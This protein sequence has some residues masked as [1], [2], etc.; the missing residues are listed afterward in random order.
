MVGFGALLVSVGCQAG[1]LHILWAA[2]APQLPHSP[3][4]P[5]H[6]QTSS[7]SR[8]GPALHNKGEE[9][10]VSGHDGAQEMEEK[11]KVLRKSPKEGGENGDLSLSAGKP[12]PGRLAPPR[13]AGC[14]TLQV[15]ALRSKMFQLVEATSCLLH[16]EHLLFPLLQKHPKDS[17]EFN[18][19]CSHRALQR[20]EQFV[21]DLHEAHQ[22]LQSVI[23]KLIC[24]LA[25]FPSDSS[26]PV[27]SALREILQNPLAV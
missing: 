20:E 6:T 9:L 7:A 5:S 10:V 12:R 1:D 14:G 26:I 17:N 23:E 13:L 27:Q 8:F 16:V 19:I 15:M 3:S 24:S 22:C 4:Q 11:R 18:N 21:K 25:V 2:A